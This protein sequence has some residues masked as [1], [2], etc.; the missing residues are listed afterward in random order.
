MEKALLMAYDVVNQQNI[1]VLYLNK[2]LSDVQIVTELLSVKA[3]LE[4]G[5]LENGNLNEGE[6]KR[7]SEVSGK[8]YELPLYFCDISDNIDQLKQTIKVL[9]ENE[10][11]KILFIDY[12]IEDEEY[13]IELKK[14]T[15]IP[16]IA[17]PY[18]SQTSI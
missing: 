11:V 8:L 3:S 2:K 5:K 9:F 15:T 7:I 18:K 10:G 12:E 1:P 6:F 13:V 14:D 16:I 17:I 4:N